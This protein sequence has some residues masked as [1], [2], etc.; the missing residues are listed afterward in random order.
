M[1]NKAKGFIGGRDGSEG[2]FGKSVHGDAT[3]DLGVATR[4]IQ[5]L[6]RG[7]VTMVKDQDHAHCVTGPTYGFLLQHMLLYHAHPCSTAPI[8]FSICAPIK[9]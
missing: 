9:Y 8:T 6:V 2:Q 4:G 7:C 1:Q 5:A 3:F